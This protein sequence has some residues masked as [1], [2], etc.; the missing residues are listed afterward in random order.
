MHSSFHITSSELKIVHGRSLTGYWISSTKGL[1]SWTSRQ[2]KKKRMIWYDLVNI[3]IIFTTSNALSYLK[4]ELVVVH[5]SLS[6]QDRPYD[7]PISP[8]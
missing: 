3:K 7:D 1:A 5:T 6:V 8:V 2:H 4:D